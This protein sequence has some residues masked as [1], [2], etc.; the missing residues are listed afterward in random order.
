MYASMVT[1][2]DEG[3]PRRGQWDVTTTRRV[4]RKRRPPPRVDGW[5]VRY[6]L[7]AYLLVL[8]VSVIAAVGSG[9]VWIQFRSDSKHLAAT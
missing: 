5:T 4:R 2:A 7:S 8:A 1:G 3:G 6:V 9:S